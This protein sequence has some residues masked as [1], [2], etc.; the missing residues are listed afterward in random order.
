ML[1]I[2]QIWYLSQVMFWQSI[3]P[4]RFIMWDNHLL[5]FSKKYSV[6]FLEFV[7][8]AIT[9]HTC[10]VALYISIECLCIT[11]YRPSIFIFGRTM[12]PVNISPFF[13]LDGGVLDILT[14]LFLNL[15]SNV[16]CNQYVMVHT[17]IIQF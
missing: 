4:K 1:I 12:L 11:L 13:V 17:T 14:K 5:H 16:G 8:Y 10:P 9:C 7:R 6:Q 3:S 15:F 2:I